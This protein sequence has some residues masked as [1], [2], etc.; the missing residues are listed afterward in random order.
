LAVK[1]SK[2]RNHQ[3][4]FFGTLISHARTLVLIEKMASNGKS[5]Y[6]VLGKQA[7]LQDVEIKGLFFQKYSFPIDVTNRC[8]EQLIFGNVNKSYFNSPTLHEDSLFNDVR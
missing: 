2:K 1:N 8:Y 5:K 7:D 3:D 6:A 4:I